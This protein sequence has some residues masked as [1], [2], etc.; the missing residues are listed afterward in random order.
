VTNL[1]IIFALPM[2]LRISSIDGF[3]MCI[4]DVLL[5]T[6]YFTAIFDTDEVEEIGLIIDLTN[7]RH[8]RRAGVDGESE[9][10]SV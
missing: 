10:D 5:D 6:G 3:N 1:L 2:N 7:G 4:D 9:K 8:R